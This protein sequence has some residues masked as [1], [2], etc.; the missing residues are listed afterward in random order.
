MH[1]NEIIDLANLYDED[2]NWTTYALQQTSEDYDYVK[3]IFTKYQ[4]ELHKQLYVCSM[5]NKHV[6]VG[7]KV[8]SLPVNRSIRLD[9]LS[10]PTPDIL[11]AKLKK[12]P[13]KYK[14]VFSNQ[15]PLIYCVS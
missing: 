12:L 10:I 14:E 6:I 11:D 3:T 15:E 5:M 4:S 8:M 13:V 9:K 1:I 2:P 7:T